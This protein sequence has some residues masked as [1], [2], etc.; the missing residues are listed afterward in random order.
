MSEGRGASDR[1]HLAQ[2]N[3]ARMMASLDDPAMA[4]FVAQ[5]ARVN[6]EADGSPGFVWRLQTPEGDSTGVRA[7][8]DSRVLVNLSVWQDLES[9][10]AYTYR[11]GHV[12]P[13]RAR[14]Q[15]FEPFDGA[16]LALWWIPAGTLPTLEEARA[17]LDQ[18]DREGPTPAAF[19]FKR[20]FGPDGAPRERLLRPMPV[21]APPPSREGGAKD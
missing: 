6:A 4:D 17:R 2:V 7:Y 20:V 3:V 14:R 18:L 15:W 21:G 19:T 9:L 12:E 16:H 10:F 8:A 11:S 5:I 13:F 1:F